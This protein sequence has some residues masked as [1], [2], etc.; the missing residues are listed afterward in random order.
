MANIDRALREMTWP[1]ARVLGKLL[2]A[3]DR[4]IRRDLEY[5]RDQLHAPIEFDPRK[6]GYR[7]TEPTYRLPFLQLT[8]GELVALFLAEQLLRQYRGTPYGPDLARAFAKIT[9]ALTD[10]ISVDAERLSRAI[11]FRTPAPA[12]F[13]L[14]ILRTLIMAIL[15]R[16][17]VVMDYWSA[18]RNALGRRE[19]NPYHLMS[20]DGQYY[21]IAYCH[22]RKEPRQFVPGRIKAIEMTDEFFSPDDSFQLDEYLE[23]S[24]GVFRGDGAERHR[25][26]L[27][28]TGT[29]VRYIS[30]R[31]WPVDHQVERTPSGDLVVSFEVTHLR[32]VERLVFTWAP[33]CEALE[34]AEL[35]ESVG[36]ALAEAARIHSMPNESNVAR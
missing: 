14:D 9:A 31:D 34:P 15:Q 1:N 5:M 21:L 28:F 23:G 16:K 3:S 18:S 17:R 27:R 4:T 30:E 20:Y 36:K 11:S 32:E 33:D 13:D 22:T 25:V 10:P 35:R 26:R 7:Y 8:E 6:N 24:L 19:V 12:L 2:E 29:A